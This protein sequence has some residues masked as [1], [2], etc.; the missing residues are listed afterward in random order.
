MKSIF[1]LLGAILLFSRLCA[2]E[3]VVVTLESVGDRVRAQNP[4]LK[5]ARLLI[6]EAVGRARDAGRLDNPT[7]ESS[8][9][10]GPG[11]R[12]STLDVG[13]AQAFP[14]TNRLGL[15]KEIS[16]LEIKA[17]EAEVD[18]MQLQLAASAREVVV[19]LLAARARRDLLRQ[20]I[21]INQEFANYLQQASSKGEGSALDAGQARLE[22]NK[23]TLELTQ[24]AVDEASLA[25]QLR[26]LLGMAPR[27]QITVAGD[28]PEPRALAPDH[29]RNDLPDHQM[30][31]IREQAAGREV[32]L[33]RARRVDDVE[34][35]VFANSMKREDDPVG[36][37][38]DRML[39]IK[40]SIP[41]PLWN[42]NQGAIDEAGARHQRRQLEARELS[43]NLM[44]END[45]ARE[46]MHKWRGLIT[47]INDKLL[48][49]AAQQVTQAERAYRAGQ[50]E[51]QTLLQA[52]EQQL[53]LL[54]ARLDALCQYHLARV[55]Y[56][57]VNQPSADSSHEN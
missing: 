41:L 39:G 2:G 3:A 6:Q 21:A 17:A 9:E 52:R 47:E 4:Q 46:E 50:T 49:L 20:Q 35:G 56:P 8:Y 14:L 22:S 48:P 7:F 51:I 5:S 25:N 53:E 33:E 44:L 26:S 15:Q 30:A 45:C 16:V 36:L 32:E 13:L 54:I 28:L 37:E 12:E 27:E 18:Q 38:S 10:A 57:S 43:R 23:L 42:R 11:L 29:D 24:L 31:T 40:L 55:R 1:A 19:S 34:L